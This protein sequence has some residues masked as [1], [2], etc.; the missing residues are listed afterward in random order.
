MQSLGSQL[1]PFVMKPI[2]VTGDPTPLS[3]T[4]PT[5]ATAMAQTILR[6]VAQQGGTSGVKILPVN[7]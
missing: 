3:T 6:A 4:T 2:N 1:D 5:H 7:V